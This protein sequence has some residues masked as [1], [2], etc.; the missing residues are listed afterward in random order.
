MKHL[1]FWVL[2]YLATVLLYLFHS[3]TALGVI[4]LGGVSLWLIGALINQRLVVRV[5]VCTCIA[6]I[7]GAAL[8][9]LSAL[10]LLSTSL[11]VINMIAVIV[12]CELLER[13]HHIDSHQHSILRI[14]TSILTYVF[15]PAMLFGAIGVSLVLYQ[16]TIATQTVLFSAVVGT[17]L[18]LFVGTPFV[19]A[20]MGRGDAYLQSVYQFRHVMF[21]VVVISSMVATAAISWHLFS[22]ATV[23]LFVLSVVF[24][25]FKALNLCSFAVG[26]LVSAALNFHYIN[27]D[28][29]LLDSGFY[30]FTSIAVGYVTALF[31]W[32][33]KKL[34]A[35]SSAQLSQLHESFKHT[36]ELSP[37]MLLTID[38]SGTVQEVSQGFAD[39]IGEPKELLCGRPFTDFMTAQGQ[40]AF[41]KH[42]LDVE[43]KFVL[44]NLQLLSSEGEILTVNLKAELFGT[45]SGI[46][47]LCF[48]QDIS[49][50]IE[51][52][53]VLEQEK[54]L[55]EVTLSSIGDG[56][57]CTDVNS[58]VT[59][60]NPVAEAVLAKLT[61]EVKGLPFDEVMPLYNEDTKQP[62]R[63]LTDYCIKNNKLMELP[64]LTCVKNH[65][66]LEF[67]IQDSISPIYL[68]NGE[69][70]GAVMVFQDVTESRIMSRKLSHLAHHDVLTGLPN[71]LLLQDR[72]S[73]FC[74]R[75][76]REEHNF[77]VVFIDLDKFKKINDSL[78]HAVGDSLLKKVAKRLTNCI[79]SCDT[80][81]RMGGDE[82]VLLLDAVRSRAQVGKVVEK[83]LESVSGCYE[84]DTVQVELA[85]SAGVA[86]YPEDGDSADA[87]MKHADT[88][89]YRAKKV[90][91]SNYQFYSVELDKDAEFKIEQESA[92]AK[93][94]K[95]SEFIPY[96][97]PVVNAQSFLLEKLEMLARWDH[98]GELAG[99]HQ[100]IATAEEAN[101]IGK[102][103]EQLLQKAFRDFS[104]WLEKMPSLTLSVNISVLQLIEPEFIDIFLCSLKRFNVPPINVEIEI[105]ESSLVSNLDTMKQ[106]LLD[107]KSHGIRVA[108]DDFGTGYSSL[109]YLKHL[110]FDTIKVDQKFVSDL[111]GNIDG[112]E[113][114]IVIVHMA[115]SLQVNCVA[116]GVETAEQAR[117]LADAGCHQLQGYYFSKPKSARA[118]DSIIEAGVSIV[119]SRTLL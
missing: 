97:Q 83:I 57:I 96:Y 28:S 26:G 2:G 18:A 70:V 91:R 38:S 56:V 44:S 3:P 105:T 27:A 10:N 7:N 24:Y 46:C 86:I 4:S 54:E 1:L 118:I 82:F 52:A 55:L 66:K 19:L 67:A 69:I 36:F 99:P 107:L 59:Y 115:Q 14:V 62:I 64:E 35:H 79:R 111:T 87:L 101:L 32:R 93:G 80:V 61:R 12:I 23:A 58:K 11:I 45:P 73:Q 17:S 81:S 95:N 74:R 37:E 25:D 29:G 16:T 106:T 94:I 51:L 47:T 110:S 116:E 31:V 39:A 43:S 90:A 40:Q 85:V 98:D 112:G 76:L 9:Y 15:I 72:L 53:E 34:V 103:C 6:M 104:S 60:M 113:L 8:A 119:Q 42:A 114:A 100:F 63:G 48:L 68:K 21:C 92:I 41:T 71:R 33:Y 84:L 5:A 117:I 50:Q 22:A 88:A 108:I 77:A 30:A 89:M 78:G 65:L 75:A 109:S 102:V 49:E 20:F 13:Y